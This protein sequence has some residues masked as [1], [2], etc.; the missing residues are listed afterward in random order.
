MQNLQSKKWGAFNFKITHFGFKKA[1]D[2][3][4]THEIELF[5]EELFALFY[6]FT[7]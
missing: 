6:L 3:F 5:W 2:I 7:T 4:Y 1:S